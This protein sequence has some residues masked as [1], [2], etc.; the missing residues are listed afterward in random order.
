MIPS[1]AL[2]TLFTALAAFGCAA[3]VENE[4][5]S[6]HEVGR[7]GGAGLDACLATIGTLPAWR[8]MTASRPRSDANPIDVLEIGPIC[9]G[10][11]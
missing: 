5:A 8:P 7:R 3:G 4:Q 10:L 9:T 2:L 1:K 6:R 11:G